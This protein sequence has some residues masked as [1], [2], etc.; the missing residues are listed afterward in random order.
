MQALGHGGGNRSVSPGARAVAAGSGLR[1]GLPA[2][3]VASIACGIEVVAAGLLEPFGVASA[4]GCLTW[5][6][7]QPGH[8]RSLVLT[9]LA[10]IS[11]IP[12]AE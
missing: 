9:Q 5:A 1:G 6:W 12:P 4:A 7:A 11:A 8:F 2:A 10:S 3:A